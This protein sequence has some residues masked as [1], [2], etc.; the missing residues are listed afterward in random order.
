[1][2]PATGF[3]LFFEVKTGGADLSTPQKKVNPQIADG[4][5]LLTDAQADRLNVPQGS[6]LK[7]LLGDRIGAVKEL[8]GKSF[9]ER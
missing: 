4:T 7:D 6:S 9:K 3:I 5:A 1:L 8:R 2:Y